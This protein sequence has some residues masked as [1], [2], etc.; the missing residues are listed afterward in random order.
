MGTVLEIF[1][2]LEGMDF[3]NTGGMGQKYWGV[4]I[5]TIPPGFAAL[6]DII[7]YLMRRQEVCVCVCTCVCV[8][9]CLYVYLYPEGWMLQH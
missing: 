1:K 5:P 9:A 6:P 4:Y 3:Q 7:I 8:S 2:I